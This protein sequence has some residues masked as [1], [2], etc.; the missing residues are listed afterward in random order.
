MTPQ[1]PDRPDPLANSYLA[2][3]GPI[4]VRVEPQFLHDYSRADLARW[5]WAYTVEICNAGPETVQ[6]LARRWT[7]TDGLGQ[8]QVVEGEGVVGEKPVLE[9]G[10]CFVYTSHV[11]LS[12]PSGFMAG[13]YRM[14]TEDGIGFTAR[15]PDFS[16]DSPEATPLRAN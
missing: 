4:T 11:P 7:I 6:L 8:Q 1:A 10:Q 5:V 2:A 16:L 13:F 9:A 12:T 15:I 3:S 14:I